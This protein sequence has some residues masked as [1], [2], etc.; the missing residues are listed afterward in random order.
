MEINQKDL[1]K[2]HSRRAND[3]YSN[4]PALEKYGKGVQNLGTVIV[5]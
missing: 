2:S 1:E 3:I 4:P 5:K